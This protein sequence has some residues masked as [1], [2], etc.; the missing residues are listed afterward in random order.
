MIRTNPSA[1]AS[2]PAQ[3]SAPDAAPASTGGQSERPGPTMN[4]A[5]FQAA[6]R[7][8]QQNFVDWIPLSKTVELAAEA[9]DNNQP[10]VV[11]AA[12]G[13]T[14]DVLYL[15]VKPFMMLGNLLQMA[16]ARD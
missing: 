3:I 8:Y 5:N 11:G 9:R 4:R 1:P 6:E 2:A 7:A 13:A 14:L 16:I 15:F 12:R 10:M